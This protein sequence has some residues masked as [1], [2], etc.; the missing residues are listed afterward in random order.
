MSNNSTQWLSKKGIRLG[1]LNICH[2]K[3]KKDEIADILANSGNSFHMFC[4]SESHLNNKITDQD[5]SISGFNIIRKD[6]TKKLETGLVMYYSN[7]I[8]VKRLNN[9]ENHNIESIW[10]EM[11]VKKN[12]PIIIGFVYR[13]P[14]ENAGWLNRFHTMME[15]VT[16]E[17]K[18][19][20]MLGDFNIDLLKKHTDW[21][22]TYKQYCLKQL[23]KTPTRITKDSETLIDHIYVT[24][25]EHFKE[26]SS[27][28][29]GRSD[30]NAICATWAKKGVKIPKSDHKTITIRNFT[31]FEQS[32]FL[33]DLAQAQM[34]KIYQSSNPDQALKDW[35]NI[36]NGI[37]DKHAPFMTKR[38]RDK[39]K[40]P[41]ISKEID[42]AKV[43]REKLKKEKKFEEFKKQRNKVTSLIRISRKKI[44]QRF[45]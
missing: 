37:Y 40:P 33:Q 31:K 44:L 18:E 45:S 30:H 23:I 32:R 15:A 21:K 39:Q 9:I 19:I 10:I 41:W 14:A 20:I 22:R 13:N 27:S 5:L 24:N 12:K 2:I 3:N 28:I 29:F 17:D 42:E 43:L 25:K 34:S 38:V 8:E 11:K 4:F 36:F 16:F 26:H 7:S 6:A 35:L 1:Y